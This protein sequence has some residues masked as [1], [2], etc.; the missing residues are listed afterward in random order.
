VRLAPAVAEDEREQVAQAEDGVVLEK[1][2]GD[3]VA[4][5]E[6][7]PAQVVAPA[8]QRGKEVRPRGIVLEAPIHGEAVLGDQRGDV[9]TCRN[10]LLDAAQERVL[11]DVERRGDET[12]RP[13][14]GGIEARRPILGRPA[15]VVPPD[16]LQAS[17]RRPAR[18]AWSGWDRQSRRSPV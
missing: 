3:G 9:R 7:L 8:L 17:A 11:A 1:R 4:D 13:V 14:R 15:D 2:E 18:A 12:V 6:H 5:G 16:G 10:Q